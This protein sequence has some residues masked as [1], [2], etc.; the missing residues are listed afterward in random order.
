MEFEVIFYK[1]S[2][3]ISPIEVFLLGLIKTNKILFNKVTDGIAKL[4]YEIYHKE[5][6]SKYLE[7]GLWELRVRSGTD[8]LRI[9]Y[10]F[11]KGRIIVLLHVFIKKQQKTPRRELEITRRRLGEIRLRELN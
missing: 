8:L 4:K 5:P 10:T 2:K 9:F 11:R 6:L 7:P 1:D 3:G